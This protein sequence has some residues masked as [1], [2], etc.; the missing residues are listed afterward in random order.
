[1]MPVD[2]GQKP[3]RQSPTWQESLRA[4]A[5]YLGLGFQFAGTMVFFIGGGYLLDRWLGLM[6]WLTIAGALLG[7]VAVLA[8][9]FRISTQLGQPSTKSSRSAKTPHDGEGG[10]PPRP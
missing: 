9:L 3:A 4:A 1:M 7:I 6:P 8:L 5:P 10:V 2:P